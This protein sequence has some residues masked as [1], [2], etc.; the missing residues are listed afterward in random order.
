MGLRFRFRFASED[1][2]RYGDQWWTFNEADLA[3][4]RSRELIA[5]E[6]E[7]RAEL[8]INVYDAVM[9][10]RQAHREATAA[11]LALMWIARRMAGGVEPLSEFDPM[12]LA[13]RSEELPE[14]DD[15]DPP[16][17]TSSPSPESSGA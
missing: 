10:L 5:I 7:L 2:E 13:A 4:M 3:R 8:G 15:A 12:V 11:T 14:G 6:R 17:R 9:S 1:H 16:V